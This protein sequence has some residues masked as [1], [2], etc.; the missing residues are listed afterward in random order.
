[1]LGSQSSAE[2]FRSEPAK[3]NAGIRSG[4]GNHPSITFLFAAPCWPE[5]AASNTIEVQIRFTVHSS[6]NFKE[7][8]KILRREFARNS[9]TVNARSMAEP[10]PPP[11]NR[12]IRVERRSDRTRQTIH[13]RSHRPEGP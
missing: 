9:A 3:T 6:K 8:R 13:G 12:E 11:Q 4:F 1:M 7:L 2:I 5:S 10:S